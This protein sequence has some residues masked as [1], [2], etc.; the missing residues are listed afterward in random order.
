[1]KVRITIRGQSYT[2]RSDEEDVDI[3]EVA[4]YLDAR[5]AEVSATGPSLDDYTIAMLAALNI[6]SDFRRFQRNVDQEL[7]SIDRELEGAMVL[8]ESAVPPDDE[9]APE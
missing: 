1:M 2:V 7:A 9:G 6:A 3:R 4:R 5:M 8:M